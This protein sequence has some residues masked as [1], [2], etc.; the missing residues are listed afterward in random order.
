MLNHPTLTQLEELGLSG[1]AKAFGELL[2]SGDATGLSLTE[3]LGLLLDREASSRRDKRLKARLKY[4]NLRH[5]AV[6][7]DVDYKHPRKLDRA[8]FQGLVAGG[9]IDA[10]DNLIVSGKT[11]SASRGSL[12]RLA[13]RL[14]ATTAPSSISACRSCSAISRSP[15]ATAAMPGCSG[16]CRGWTCSSW[17]ISGLARS[18]PQPARTFWRSW[19]SATAGAP[20]SSPAS[21]RWRHGTQLIGEPTYADAILDRI[22]HNAHRIELDGETIRKTRARAGKRE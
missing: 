18:T 4:A 13:T 3:G 14:A 8:V 7:E 15:A 21:R 16:R 1:M 9:W 19:R 5:Q 6:V 12:V 2:A 17:T 10:H 22:V 11:G 20:P